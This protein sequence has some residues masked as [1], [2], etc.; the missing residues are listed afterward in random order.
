[1]SNKLFRLDRRFCF[2]VDENDI[3]D[4]G[5]VIE[6]ETP[7]KVRRYSESCLLICG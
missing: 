6:E 1:M 5:E 2:V 4:N 7:T 3:Q